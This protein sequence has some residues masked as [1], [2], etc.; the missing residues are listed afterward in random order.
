MT[1]PIILKER[2]GAAE[3]LVMRVPDPPE[4]DTIVKRSMH[5]RQ[6]YRFTG[7][8]DGVPVYEAGA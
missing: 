6:E 7:Y 3:H 1:G 5:W 2:D 8:E 4:S